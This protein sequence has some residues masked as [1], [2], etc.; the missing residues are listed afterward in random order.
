LAG[1]AA[2]RLDGAV[3]YVFPAGTA[4]AAGG[5]LIVVGFDPT[6]ET[7]R[8]NAFITAYKMGPSSAGIVIVGPWQGDLSNH[9]ERLALEKSLPGDSPAAPVAWEVVDEVIYGD[10]APWP[11]SP[12]GQGDALQRISPSPDDS[13]NDPANWKAAPPT[14]GK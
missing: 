7:A 10:T 4:L 12:D 13:G 3:N 2:W 5:R 6:V 11:V 1:T 8:L 9:G 14:P